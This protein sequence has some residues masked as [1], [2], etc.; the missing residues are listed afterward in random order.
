MPAPGRTGQLVDAGST[1]DDLVQALLDQTGPAAAVEGPFD[2]TVGGYSG[3]RVDVTSPAASDLEGCMVPGLQLWR[4]EAGNY[5]VILADWDSSIYIVDV[6]GERVVLTSQHQQSAP[7]ADLAELD[8][9]M[10]S[11]VF[12]PRKVL[13]ALRRSA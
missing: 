2:V 12:Q 6:E 3:Q 7:A 5:W 8:A 13:R 9:V 4:D 11:I 1:V 10:E